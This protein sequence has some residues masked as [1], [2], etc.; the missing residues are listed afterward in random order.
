MKF[1]IADAEMLLVVWVDA[2]GVNTD[3]EDIE[4]L[5]GGDIC[6]NH[7]VGFL[8]EETDDSLLLV[9][10]MAASGTQGC[11]DIQIPKAMIRKITYLRLGEER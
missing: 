10:H 6:I 4:N 3:W 1:Q 11:G 8:I 7:S 5:M 2:Y 9:P